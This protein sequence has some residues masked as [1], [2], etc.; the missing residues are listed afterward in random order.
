MSLFLVATMLGND[1]W[2]HTPRAMFPLYLDA[3]KS[4]AEP[5]GKPAQGI[6]LADL[7]SLWTEMLKRK[8]DSDLTGNGV[9]H[10]CDFGHRVYASAVLSLLVESPR[11][12]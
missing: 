12:P 3:L 8:R 11:L 5:D 9:N 1:Q 6:A 10:P 4:L 7:T 2:H